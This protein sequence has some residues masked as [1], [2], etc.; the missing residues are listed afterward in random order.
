M[1]LRVCI[2]RF[3]DHFSDHHFA[4]FWQQLN[5]NESSNRGEFQAGRALLDTLLR[6]DVLASTGQL[7]WVMTGSQLDEVR[8]FAPLPRT[9]YLVELCLREALFPSVGTR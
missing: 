5:K 7:R 2:G 8:R 9:A 4:N 6:S 3:R 1:K